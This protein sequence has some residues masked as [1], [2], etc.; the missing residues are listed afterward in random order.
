M[1]G[2]GGLARDDRAGLKAVGGGA[3]QASVVASGQSTFTAREGRQFGLTVGVAFLIVAGLFVWREHLPLSLVFVGLGLSLVVGGLA[4]PSRLGPVH[5][6]W[7]SGAR[8]IS[9]V[10]TPVL[11]AVVYFL[12]LTPTGI[13]RRAFGGNPLSHPHTEHGYWAAREDGGR[14][15]LE[16]QF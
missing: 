16:R 5:R 3:T 12:V 7:M 8:A 10:T 13:L 1:A 2:G 6:I 11:L 4:V 14:S 15:D 9:R